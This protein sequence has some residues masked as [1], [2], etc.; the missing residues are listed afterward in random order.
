MANFGQLW[1]T[2]PG[3]YDVSKIPSGDVQCSED[4]AKISP[5]G[6]IKTIIVAPGVHP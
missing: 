6:L 2:R 3:Q 1:K 5:K 4:F